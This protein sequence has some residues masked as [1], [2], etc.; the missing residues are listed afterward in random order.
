MDY[1]INFLLTRP[2]QDIVMLFGQ[3]GF[4]FALITGVLNKKMKPAW[5]MSLMTATIL[6]VYCVTFNTL[7]LYLTGAIQSLSATCW[8]IMFYQG[9]R[10][11]KGS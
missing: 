8:W 5:Q 10:R 6:S 2:W 3:F 1:F 9:F 7:G 11:R 4:L